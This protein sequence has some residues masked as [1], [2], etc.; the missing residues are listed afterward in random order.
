M[1]LATLNV[2]GSRD[3]C[4][5]T[6]AR[7]LCQANILCLTETWARGNNIQNLVQH[8]MS[9][10]GP[11]VMNHARHQGGVRLLSSPSTP[12][13]YKAY[14]SSSNAQV[15]V[16]QMKCGLIVIGAYVAPM[17][18][19]LAMESVLRWVRPW[20]RARFVLL[21]DLN[22]RHRRWHTTHNAYGTT[23]YAWAQKNR[24]QISAPPEP[25][26]INAHGS[27]TIDL[28]LT[29]GLRIDAV[30]VVPG[31]HDN[32]TDHRL[33]EATILPPAEGTAYCIPR[34]VLNDPH[35]RR[36]A[37]AHYERVIPDL[38]TKL[39]QIQTTEELADSHSAWQNAMLVPW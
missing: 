35:R 33:V 1:R 24:V 2:G 27:S 7:L 8:D 4:T 18:G 22:A 17:R 39:E 23:L 13:R 29:R 11:K 31:T 12:L 9:I 37:A 36:R 38:A 21:G 30:K 34:R 28:I 5:T 25:T 32:V 3:Q 20:L 10:C 16:A 15:L 19:R 6:D 26:L 14:Y